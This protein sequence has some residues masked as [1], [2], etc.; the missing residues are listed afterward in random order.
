MIPEDWDAKKIHT[1]GEKDVVLTGPFGSLLHSSDYAS[2]G[3]PLLLV[4]SMENGQLSGKALP[5]VNF[6]KARELKRYWLK[7]GDIVFTRVG[8]VGKTLHIDENKAGWMF[9]GQTL[10]I[11][12]NNPK[13]CPRFIAYYFLSPNAFQ[14]SSITSLGTTRPSINTNILS[15]RWVPVPPFNE[16][17]VIVKF[18]SDLDAKM[19]LS[20][21]MNKVL[22][23]IAQA[24]FKSWF[25]DLLA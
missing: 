19:E 16:Q 20:R 13:I 6:A 14:L 9:S 5:K 7:K 3:V 4:N 2:N 24:V 17:E 15:N 22:E 25:V 12:F 11:R 8:V 1:L 18:L 21:K 10:R 23:Q